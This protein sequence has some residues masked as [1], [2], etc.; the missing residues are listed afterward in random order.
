[1][2]S[3]AVMPVLALINLNTAKPIPA[4]AAAPI[5]NNFFIIFHSFI[6]TSI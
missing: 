5:I 6:Y 3:Y 4:K 1:M 2:R